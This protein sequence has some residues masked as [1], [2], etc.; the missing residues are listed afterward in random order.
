[1]T[2]KF[3]RRL[4]GPIM[5]WTVLTTI[6]TWLP[7]VRIIGRPEGYHWKVLGLAGEGSQGP[8]WVFVPFF[9]FAVVLLF[10]SERGPR[11]LFYP[12]LIIWQLLVLAI[13]T[14]VLIQGGSNGAWQGQGLHWKIPIW[15]AVVLGFIFTIL[16]IAWVSF[17]RKNAAPPTPPWCRI[18]I[19]RLAGSL[20]LLVI[21]VALFRV[22]TNYNWV[23]AVAIVTTIMHWL[24]LSWSFAGIKKPQPTH[25]EN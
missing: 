6:F 13:V 5:F 22:G 8:F 4:L 23:T 25:I 12:L 3:Y 9:V 19:V 18:N 15:I 11:H 10:L 14:T 24:A 17:D 2:D 21:A 1:M 16:A 20:V 7:L